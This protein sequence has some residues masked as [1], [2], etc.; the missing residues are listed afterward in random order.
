M[1]RDHWTYRLIVRQTNDIGNLA[2]LK[3]AHALSDK[4]G[5]VST[6]GQLTGGHT[7]TRCL[8]WP[9]V[10]KEMD[11]LTRSDNGNAEGR[12]GPSD[13]LTTS[14]SRAGA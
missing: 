3:P 10:P 11:G 6:G 4:S 9:S 2:G 5:I 8:I 1:D 12:N 13:D 14:H 7:L